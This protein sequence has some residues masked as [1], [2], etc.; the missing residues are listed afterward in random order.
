VPLN[1]GFVGR[2]E[3]TGHPAQKPEKVFE[4]LILMATKPGDLVIDPMCGSGTTGA[5]C[6]KL[7]RRANL[8]DESEEYVNVAE[9]RLGVKWIHS[10]KNAFSRLRIDFWG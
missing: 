1:I 7:G 8:C 10:P 4:P 9:N 3:Q 2:V 5:L 6:A